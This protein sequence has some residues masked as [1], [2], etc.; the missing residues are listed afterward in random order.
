MSPE[1]IANYLFPNYQLPH[2]QIYIS[3]KYPKERSQLTTLGF[4]ATYNY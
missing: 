1:S 2:S 4:V 3:P